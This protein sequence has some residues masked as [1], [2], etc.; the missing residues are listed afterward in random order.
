MTVGRVALELA[1][2]FFCFTIVKSPS[3]LS[4]LEKRPNSPRAGETQGSQTIALQ[5][6]AHGQI[7]V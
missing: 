6:A 2:K 5:A 4:V 7:R 1:N 3:Y